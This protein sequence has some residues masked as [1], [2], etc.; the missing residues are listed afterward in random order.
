MFAFICHCNKKITVVI[1][2]WLIGVFKIALNH[3]YLHYKR[4]TFCWKLQLQY[5]FFTVR[6]EKLWNSLLQKVSL[7]YEIKKNSKQAAKQLKY[8]LSPLYLPRDLFINSFCI[9]D[10]LPLVNHSKD[11]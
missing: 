9:I 8:T 10:F 5:V 3:S 2:L 11:L 7:D 6:A 1:S 4:Y